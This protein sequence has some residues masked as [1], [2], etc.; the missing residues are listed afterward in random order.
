MKQMAQHTL[1]NLVAENLHTIHEVEGSSQEKNLIKPVIES[2]YSFN[3][4]NN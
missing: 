2:F 3:M 4:C 1:A